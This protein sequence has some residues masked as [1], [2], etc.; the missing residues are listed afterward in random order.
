[1]VLLGLLAYSSYSYS[2]THLA[3]VYGQTANA[4]ASGTS[5]GMQTL[6]PQQAGLTVSGV[7]YQY[8]TV[9]NTEDPM[10]VHVQNENL[11][12]PGYIFRSSDDWTGK[13][14][15]TIN[16]LV[17]V[18]NIPLEYWG[19]GS[20]EV[21]GVGGVI[22]TT[23]I[24]N[25]QYDPCYDPQSDPACP[26]Y[27]AEILLDILDA[28]QYVKDPLDDELIQA[29]LEKKVEQDDEEEEEEDRKRMLAKLE[30]VSRLEAFLGGVNVLL[31]DALAA[32]KAAE[33]VAL[34]YIPP[35]YYVA[36]D[37]KMYEETLELPDAQ[38]PSNSATAR[39][40]GLAQELL[41]EQMVQSQ[42]GKLLPETTEK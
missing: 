40:V 4:A 26:G 36:L 17:P 28:T 41:H 35:T 6:L 33:L 25:Y 21:E 1:M 27:K 20:I 12:G 22:D 7:I 23:V 2:D 29:E 15:N 3:P 5:W 14:G 18:T 30:Q 11:Q 13:P 8:T 31:V 42:Y 19:K 24:Y 37:G 16:R 9:K 32:A 38:L 10:V 39:R 34:N